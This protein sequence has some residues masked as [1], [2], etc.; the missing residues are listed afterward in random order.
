M[1]TRFYF[2]ATEASAVNPAFDAGWED[3]SEALRRRLEDVK[4]V[5]AIA[6]GSTIN[7][8]EDVVRDELDRQYVSDPMAAGN[9][10]TSGVS[11][12]A[13]Q[14]MVRE[15]ANTDNVDRGILGVRIVSQDGLTVRATL[16]AVANYGPTLE[17]INNATMRN[18]T[19]ADGDLVGATYT[20]VD[21]D[22]LVV[23]I[24]YQSSV[25]NTTPQAAAK[26]GQNA[27]DLPVNETQT[28]DGAGWIET[29]VTITFQAPVGPPGG[30]RTLALTGVGI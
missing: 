22:R 20:T 29:S 13:M 18:K 5:D 4:G 23:E 15:F 25:L 27:T 14:L 24:G 19:F 10:W 28:T 7:L 17:F 16:L 11:T 3:T 9:T 12:F 8:L 21:G 1:V 30:Q 26:Y 6:A 2:P